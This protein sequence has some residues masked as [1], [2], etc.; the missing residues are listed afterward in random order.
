MAFKDE[1]PG[2]ILSFCSVLKNNSS[3]VFVLGGG[4]KIKNILSFLI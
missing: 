2:G 3:L 4:K 1:S